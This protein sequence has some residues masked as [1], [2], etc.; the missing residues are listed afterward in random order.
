MIF[1]TI[2][3]SQKTFSST[4]NCAEKDPD[5]QQVNE[6]NNI[7]NTWDLAASFEQANDQYQSAVAVTSYAE[8]LHNSPWTAGTY[9]ASV[10][11]HTY[12]L[13]L[14]LWDD[15]QK[16]SCSCDSYRNLIY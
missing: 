11:D 13:S 3:F 5:T 8:V 12:L 6:I 4:S 15:I 1:F 9:S 16:I 10:V 14:L 7:F 2:A